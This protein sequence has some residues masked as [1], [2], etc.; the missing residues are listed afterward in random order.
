MSPT[1]RQP[2]STL[3]DSSLDRSSKLHTAPE[4]FLDSTL[5]QT[6]Q[7]SVSNLGLLED[8]MPEEIITSLYMQQVGADFTIVIRPPSI[9]YSVPSKNFLFVKTLTREENNDFIT[10]KFSDW[11]NQAIGCLSKYNKFIELLAITDK[12]IDYKVHRARQEAEHYHMPTAPPVIQNKNSK[13]PPVRRNVTK[14]A[15]LS[16]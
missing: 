2:G 6:H 13:S 12:G 9:E 7:S 8:K 16:T 10:N 1:E 15:N 4:F 14:M 11:H 3:F 5:G